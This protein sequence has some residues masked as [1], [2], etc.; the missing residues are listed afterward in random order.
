MAYQLHDRHGA[1]RAVAYLCLAAAPFIVLT[2]TV[3]T[4]GLPALVL[5]AVVLT[6]IAVGAGGLVCFFRPHLMPD[7]FWLAAPTVAILFISGLNL[8]T[9]DASTGSQLF[10]LWPVLY[11]ANFLSRRVTYLNIAGVL[12]GEALVLGHVLGVEA[13]TPDWAAMGLALTMTAVVVVTLRDRADQL[14]RRLEGQALADPLTGLPNR[15]S[16]DGELADAGRW[17][18]RTG[19]P[20]ALVTLDVDHFKAINDTWGHAV[21]DEALQ[22]VADALRAVAEPADVVARL[23]GDEFVMLL[24]A[25]RRGALRAAEALRET[26]AAVTGL[27]SGAPRLSIGVAV[28]PDHAATVDQLAG[29]SD[30]ALYDAKSRGRGRVAVAGEPARHN[31]D[32]RPAPDPALRA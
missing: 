19:R 12:V 13:A 18:A 28:L 16:F 17:A 25:D 24:R 22:A 5:F 6:S 29:A 26:V 27:P 31:V 30:A 11:A 9:R 21:G 4:R 15:R 23:G 1:S 32:R 10:Y 14:L 20:L 3:L 8:A 7:F 2:S